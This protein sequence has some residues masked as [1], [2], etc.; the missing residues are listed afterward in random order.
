MNIRVWMTKESSALLL[1]RLA[2][3]ILILVGITCAWMLFSWYQANTHTAEAKF[4]ESRLAS[5]IEDAEEAIKK[6]KHTSSESTTVTIQ[7]ISLLQSAFEQGASLH[8]CELAEFEATSQFTP[9][10]TRFQK[11]SDNEGW[12]QVPVKARLRG[13][14]SGVMSALLS[15]ERDQFLFEYDSFEM[16]R[17]STTATGSIVDCLV[18][19]RVLIRAEGT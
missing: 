15:V 12:L 17:T 14:A 4:E 7:A 2:G 19:L 10:I 8:N 1:K 16:T 3:G 13:S 18:N 11:V 6:L 5:S 9:F